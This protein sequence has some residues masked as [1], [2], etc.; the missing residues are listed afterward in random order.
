MA[1]RTTWLGRWLAPAAP[2]RHRPRLGVEWLEGRSLPATGLS[3][4]V[5]A[6]PREPLPPSNLCP[7]PNPGIYYDA[8]TDTVCIVGSAGNDKVSVS[9][10]NGQFVATLDTGS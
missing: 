4:A 1:R 6:E 8:N 5:P 9:V 3:G 10:Q 2:K 7:Q